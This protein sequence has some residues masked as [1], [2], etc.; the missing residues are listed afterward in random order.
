MIN[1]ELYEKT[2]KLCGK[3]FSGGVSED[4]IRLYEDKLGVRFPQSYKEFLK[5]FGEGGVTGTYI[6]GIEDE[7][8]GSILNDTENF[9]NKVSL[10]HDYIVVKE[11]GRIDGSW[12]ICLDTGRMHDGE[13]PA[14][15]YDLDTN[16][17][18]E[19]KNNFDEVFDAGVMEKYLQATVGSADETEETVSGFRRNLPRGIGYKTCWLVIK[20][21]NKAAIS[22]ALGLSDTHEEEYTSGVKEVKKA[23]QEEV[24]LLVTSDFDD[25][26]FVI[27]SHADIFFDAGWLEEKCKGFPEVFLY[28][29]DRITETHGFA[30]VIDGKIERMYYCSEEQFIDTG[31]PLKE[32]EERKIKL[33]H[34]LD[35]LKKGLKD[36]S[37]TILN[38]DIL[39][40]LAF[41][42]SAVNL[43]EYTY[44]NVVIG[45]LPE[46]R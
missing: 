40:D 6:N 3:W 13:C 16:Q 29:T 27:C 11:V 15:K 20:G 44:D 45:M 37:C 4:L 1:R 33:P 18:S 23:G 5:E 12:L 32:E 2:I 30:K 34:D 43:D 28:C 38:E 22:E 46:T 36:N 7:G 42:N 25:R 9:R 10:P 14:V 21:S 41:E 35:E 8:F 24:K 19:Y 17:I 26:N 39:I 31:H